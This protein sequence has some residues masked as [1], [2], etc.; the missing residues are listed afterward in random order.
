MQ[1]EPGSGLAVQIARSTSSAFVPADLVTALR[2]GPFTEL[3]YVL[4]SEEAAFLA[5][6]VVAGCFWRRQ[7]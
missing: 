2:D 4:S 7:T 1:V 6:A 3:K 5:G